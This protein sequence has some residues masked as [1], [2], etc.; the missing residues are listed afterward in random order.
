MQSLFSSRFLL[1]FLSFLLFLLFLSF[2]LFLLFFLSF[3]LL[4]LD[5][6]EEDELEE[7][8][9]ELRSL[10]SSASR[11]RGAGRAGTAGRLQ[12]RAADEEPLAVWPSI[13]FPVRRPKTP[14]VC[15]TTRNT[16]PHTGCGL[17]SLGKAFFINMSTS[18]PCIDPA[19]MSCRIWW[20][21]GKGW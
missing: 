21:R 3:L 19:T 9:E 17:R 8:E 7:L 15:T 18:Y 5:L 20:H 16:S 10:S 4:C 6:D 14:S 13:S 1:S 2:L 12:L 11:G